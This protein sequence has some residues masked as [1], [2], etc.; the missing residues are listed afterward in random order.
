[1]RENTNKTILNLILKLDRN[2]AVIGAICTGTYVMA[3]ASYD[4]R[5]C[6]IHWEHIDG[7]S[8]NFQS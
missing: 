7:L 2:G 6:T 3:A 4:N 1:M 8:E 5:R